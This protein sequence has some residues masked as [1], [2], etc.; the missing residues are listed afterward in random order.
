MEL[1]RNRNKH[2]HSSESRTGINLH[3]NQSRGSIPV[4]GNLFRPRSF[5]DNGNRP[6]YHNYFRYG[7]ALC[8]YAV[9]SPAFA[10]GDTPVTAIA[11][12]QASSSGSVVNNAT[13]VLNGPYNTNTYGGGVHCQGPTLNISPFLTTSLSGQWPYESYAQLDGE[14]NRDRTGQKNSWAFNP[15]ISATISIPLDGNAQQRC[16]D[17]AQVWIER[18][19]IEGSKARL[20][21]ELVRL[22]RCGEAARQ[23]VY[24]HPDSPYASVCADVVVANAPRVVSSSQPSYPTP[25][26]L[27]PV[28]PPA[29]SPQTQSTPEARS[30]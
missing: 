23:G 30:Q 3:T 20:D 11:N 10:Q 16:Q 2:Q 26:V 4:L 29:A 22:I 17:A 27:P 18:Q 12:P 14:G 13:Q 8:V 24:F 28:S 6:N 21:F 25:T 19:R 9:G 5:K 1:F 7:L 15:G